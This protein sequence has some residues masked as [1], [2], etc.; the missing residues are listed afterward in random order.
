MS[1][2][3]NEDDAIDGVMY[4]DLVEDMR[5]WLS[6]NFSEELLIML[7]NEDTK[8]NIKDL[9]RLYLNNKEKETYSIN[10]EELVNRLFDDLVGFAFLEQY[11]YDNQIEEINGNSWKDI[12]IVSETGWRKIP[13]RFNNI[14]QGVNIIKKMMRIGGVILDEKQPIGDSYI[15]SGTRISAMIAPIVDEDIGVVFSIRKQKAKVFEIE[16]YVKTGTCLKEEFEFLVTC[17]SHGVSV[18]IAGG[19][20]SGKTSDIASLIATFSKSKRIFVIEDTRE[21]FVEDDYNNRVIFTKTRESDDPSRSIAFTNLLKTALRFHP[22]II[23]PAEIRD[24]A[25]LI[26][27]EAGRTGHAILT[28]LHANSAIEA[29]DRILSM[30]MMKNSQ[31]SESLLMK[32]IISAFPLMVFKAQL[33]DYTRKYIE[34]FEVKG[35][36]DAKKRIYGKTLYKFHVKNIEFDNKGNISKVQGEHIRVNPISNKLANRLFRNGCSQEIVKKYAG[37]NWSTND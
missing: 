26:A 19:T 11:I 10:F 35:Y 28:G 5:N 25:A 36:D 23:V 32:F 6:T 8:S 34:I 9:I 12:E 21:T 14:K 2:K 37:K 27:V 7:D 29:Y 1:S 4:G 20:S 3:V 30:C 22:D 15:S 33:P 31:L 17:L 13:D 18:G 24:E 16:E